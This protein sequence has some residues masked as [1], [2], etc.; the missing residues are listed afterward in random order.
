MPARS[1]L[2]EVFPQLLLDLRILLPHSGD[3]N[4]DPSQEL[5]VACVLGVA[6]LVLLGSEVLDL[7]AGILDFGQAEG[8]GGAFE[9]VAE[10]RE[11][12]EIFV[13]PVG[14]WSAI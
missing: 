11:L 13:L 6:V 10:G 3:G 7:L 1:S 2:A 5:V 12:R 9:E 4:L 8:S 14:S